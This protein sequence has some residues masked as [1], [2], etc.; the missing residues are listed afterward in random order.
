MVTKIMPQS[1]LCKEKDKD[2][3]VVTFFNLIRGG[4]E[5]GQNL[6]SVLQWK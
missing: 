6:E 3:T 1:W 5:Q 2:H 4:K